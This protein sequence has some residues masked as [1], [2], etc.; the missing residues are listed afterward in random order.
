MGWTVG[1]QAAS[2]VVSGLCHLVLVPLLIGHFGSATFGWIATLVALTA[3]AQFGDLGVAIALQQKLSLAWGRSDGH[4]LRRTYVVGVRLLAGLG[5]GWFVL[6]APLAWWL[7]PRL[8]PAP[9]SIDLDIQRVTW[10]ALVALIAGNVPAS[11]GAR[12]SFAIQAGWLLAAWTAAVN[13]LLVGV[14]AVAVHAGAGLFACVALLVAA[15]LAPG[16][17]AGLHLARRLQ[18]RGDGRPAGDAGEMRQLWREGLHYAPPNLAGA[19]LT[20]ATPGT[21]A[22]FGG[23]E[24][25][26]VFAALARLFGMV[27]Q[28]HATLLGPLWPAYAEARIRGDR[29]WM[30]HAF[31][32]SI[33]VTV[34]GAAI[35]AVSVVFLPQILQVWLGSG[36]MTAAP[37]FAWL[38]ACWYGAQ[39]TAQPFGQFL[40]GH[41][42]LQRIAWPNAWVHLATLAAMFALGAAW[43]GVGVV[44]ALLAGAALG[45]LPLLG[46]ETIRTLRAA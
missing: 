28:A 45:L 5:A 42:R 27:S 22:R 41:D 46:R 21:V 17:L 38:V 29:T 26:A 19:L 1:A 2:R 14:V 11:A 24:T 3:L 31:R 37:V 9:G 30:R 7:G 36:A 44:S 23:Y 25:A 34:V 12:L 20:A 13:L 32:I 33:A 10:L 16:V 40:L 4:A 35:P 15:Q 39:I 8:L 18:W 6:A 43:G